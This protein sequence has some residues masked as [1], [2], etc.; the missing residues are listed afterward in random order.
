[1][2]FAELTERGIMTNNGLVSK[3]FYFLTTTV[4][5]VTNE[6]ER[7]PTITLTL[8]PLTDE[9]FE[10]KFEI[11]PFSRYSADRNANIKTIRLKQ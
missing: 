9:E 3:K 2:E 1:M 7:A 6:G 11:D 4:I 10:S 8:L 5:D